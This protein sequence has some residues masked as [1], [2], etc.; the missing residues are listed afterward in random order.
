MRFRTWP[1]AAL[2][3]LGLLALFALSL[4]AASRRVEGIYS[5]LDAR[6]A[7]HRDVA[8]KLVQLR[9]DIQRSSIAVRDYLLERDPVQALT[10]RNRLAELRASTTQTIQQLELLT[11]PHTPGDSAGNLRAPLE[12]Y[13]RAY[14]PVF[15]WSGAERLERSSSFLRTAV[16]PR[17]NAVLALVQEI[18]RLNDRN[19]A[20]EREAAAGRHAEIQAALTR[21]LWQTIGLGLIVAAGAVLRLRVLERR[22]DEQRVAAQEAENR[23]RQLSQQLVAAQEEERRKLS[24]ELHDHVGQMLT[25]LRMELGRIERLR[26]PHNTPVSEAVAESRELVD[27]MVRTVRDLALG[28][29]PSMLDDLGLQ[30][31]L[32]WHI[33]DYTR[34]F[35]LHVDLRIE[36][37]DRELPDQ[38]RTCIYRVVQEA[39]TNCARHSGATRVAVSLRQAAGELVIAIE[40]DGVGMPQAA[41]RQGLGLKGIEERVRELE[42]SMSIGTSAAMGGTE[43]KLTLPTGGA[44]KERTVAGLAG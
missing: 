9:S 44:S 40:D 15:V 3:F 35:G 22:A 16:L 34:R 4:A 7:Y 33:R 30:S 11:A 28:L 29:R 27:A 26:M 17:R 41:Q 5:R 2:G 12:E 43:V 21:S 42:G 6:N 24:R 14:D 31:A 37:L 13:W 38:Y 8:A 18:E 1:V 32:E 20:A 36:G 19:L 25:A 39:L 23:M 10:Y